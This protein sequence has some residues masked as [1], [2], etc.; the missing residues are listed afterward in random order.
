MTDCLNC[1]ATLQGS[2]CS[3]CGQ[4]SVPA[5][6]TVAELAGDAWRELSGYDGRIAATVRG[7]LRPGYLTREYVAGR[8]A[9]Y[10]SPV[11]LYLI[12]SVIYFL[13][14]SSTPLSMTSTRRGEIAAPGG[15]QIGVTGSATG[16]DLSAEERAELLA[17]VEKAPSILRPLLRAIATDSNAFR[18]RVLTIMPR[19]FFALLPV[20]AVIVALFY[21]GR[22]FPTSLVFAVHLHA[23]AFA[24]FTLSEAAKLTGSTGFAVTVGAVMTV[25]FT[26]YALMAL[27]AVFGGSWAITV[28]KAAAIAVIYLIA[29][30]PAFAIILAWASV[31]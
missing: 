2:F 25:A 13:A 22:R 7:L 15:L 8:R 12:V 31:S 18:A 26:A 1:G 28:A 4:R 9:R 30:L 14:A 27:R 19:V 10:L 11:R 21:R 23:C 24:V 6:P 5:N 29:S 16:A 20:F 3:A 17:A